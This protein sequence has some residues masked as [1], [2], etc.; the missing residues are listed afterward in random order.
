M[1]L[2]QPTFAERCGLVIGGWLAPITAA[3]SARRRARMFHPDGVVYH[4]EVAPSSDSLELA[5]AA[6]RLT[7]A[8][9][10]RFS[11]ALWRRGFEW[12]DV[13]GVALRF[14]APRSSQQDLLL[15]T[16]RFPWT[17]PFAPFN[18]RVHSFTWNH[19]HAV[20]PFELDG[21]GAVKLRLRSPRIGNDE[22]KTR[23]R[24]LSDLTVERRAR[25]VLECRRLALPFFARHWEPL[26][27]V[28]LLDA[29]NLD[30]QALRFSPFR[31]GA[32]IH[33]TG[34]V[35]A[36]RVAAYRASQQARPAS[37]GVPLT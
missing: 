29:A 4:A 5:A 19:Y 2:D 9:L 14:D 23:E 31:D 30:Q 26:A 36:L 27:S 11:S 32:G 17:M 35:H 25:F 8:A 34:F 21:I 12:P 22:A 33:P 15:A 3:V 13:L 10:V 7:G 28:T 37:A 1:I 24:H 20:S 6:D 18:T 16:I